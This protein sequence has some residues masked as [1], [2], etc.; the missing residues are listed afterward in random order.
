MDMII[1]PILRCHDDDCH[2]GGDDDDDDDDDGDDDDEGEN[3]LQANSQHDNGEYDDDAINALVDIAM[4]VKMD[5]DINC[6]D[7]DHGD[8]DERQCDGKS[9][10]FLIWRQTPF[11]DGDASKK[12]I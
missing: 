12:T 6:D 9:L 7:V 10:S 2:D 3:G 4:I 5:D 8:D 11:R 1:L